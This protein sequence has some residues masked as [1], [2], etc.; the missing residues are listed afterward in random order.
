MSSRRHDRID[1]AVLE[2]TLR[3]AVVLSAGV[4][5]VRA[6]ALVAERSDLSGEVAPVL[7]GAADALHAGEDA[8][9]VLRRGGE[10]WHAL[11][12]VWQ[13]AATVG[14]PLA[15]T[16]RDTV[17]ALRDAA[18]VRDDVQVAL[19]EPRSTA[20][21]LGWL[22]VL[23]VPLGGALG[24]DVW[25]VLTG[26]TA[27]TVCLVG[28]VGLVVGSRL[29]ARTLERRARPGT[30]VP[31]LRA[32]LFVVALAGGVS[33]D[34]ARA[35]VE[36]AL[37][38]RHAVRSS[39]RRREEPGG[40][41]D[42]ERDRREVDEAL[43][44]SESAGA[45]ARELLRGTAWLQRQRAR[46]AGRTAAAELATRLLVPLGVCTL[47]AFLLLAVVPMILAVVRSEVL[48]F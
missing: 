28:G 48:P 20:R 24:V 27:G 15:E 42:A 29:W 14:A 13:V 18:E 17:G 37:P 12:A 9:A 19:A 22:P 34:A 1:A 25:G 47:P 21:L 26:G 32:E 41:G 38:S 5:P 46:S 45:P 31:G 36:R 43:A 30:E 11:A 4:T 35:L 44:L 23:G 40:A 3:L 8:S 10:E 2:T 7:R 16:L 39:R 33:V 6:W